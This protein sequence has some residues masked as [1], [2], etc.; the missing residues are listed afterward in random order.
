MQRTESSYA[1]WIRLTYN[2]R[3][4]RAEM[5]HRDRQEYDRRG[6]REEPPDLRSMTAAERREAKRLYEAA[7]AEDNRSG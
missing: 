3:R 4:G 5:P 1:A 2:G 7:C 6:F